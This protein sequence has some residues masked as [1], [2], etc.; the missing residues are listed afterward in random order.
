MLVC[1]YVSVCESVCMS[2][3]VGVCL[4]C[5]CML[6]CEYVCVV[7]VGNV[8]VCVSENKLVIKDRILRGTG[9]VLIACSNI[10]CG[11]RDNEGKMR[12]VEFGRSVFAR[13]YEY[14]FLPHHLSFKE[15]VVIVSS[16][17]LGGVLSPGKD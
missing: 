16:E 12:A 13:N 3:C 5:V 17:V 7:C 10:R 6:M 14:S 1:V 4:V 9:T 8:C 11:K 15:P 2:V